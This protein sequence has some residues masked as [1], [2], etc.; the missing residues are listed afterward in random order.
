MYAYWF[1]YSPY[2]IA[3]DKNGH[4]S[5]TDCTYLRI[6]S[7]TVPVPPNPSKQDKMLI[8][9]LE[10]QILIKDIKTRPFT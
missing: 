4:V 5:Q 9:M 1:G 8:K 2:E 10:N 7:S 3:F 6:L